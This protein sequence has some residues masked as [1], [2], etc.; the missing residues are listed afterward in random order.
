MD[1]NVKNTLSIVVKQDIIKT[2]NKY[3]IQ[4]ILCNSPLI[5]KSVRPRYSLYMLHNQTL[6]T[7]PGSK[8]KNWNLLYDLVASA[9]YV[10]VPAWDPCMRNHYTEINAVHL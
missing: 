10:Q 8:V 2:Q 1:Q 6:L 5:R 9:R 3:Y 7:K 4:R